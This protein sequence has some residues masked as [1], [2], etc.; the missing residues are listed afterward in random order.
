MSG[1]EAVLDCAGFSIS[2][3]S[4]PFEF[5]DFGILLE[6]GATAMNCEV[7]GLEMVSARATEITF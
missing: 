3:G 6:G 1:P 4:S 7:S 5:F 2:R